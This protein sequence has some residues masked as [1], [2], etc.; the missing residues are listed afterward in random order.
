MTKMVNQ[1]IK[2]IVVVCGVVQA[3]IDLASGGTIASTVLLDRQPG[4]SILRGDFSD[5]TQLNNAHANDVFLTNQ[6]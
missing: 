1:V 2:G 4:F 6:I 3:C 5:N